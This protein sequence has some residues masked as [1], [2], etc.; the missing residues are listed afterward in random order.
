MNQEQYIQ[1][2]LDDQID[3][4]DSKSVG[5]Q[6]WFKG[7]QVF[8]IVASASIPFIIGYF[9]D[10]SNAPKFVI[11]VLG[12][13]IAAITAVLGIYKFQE[14]WLEYRTTCESLRHEKYLFLT[15]AAPYNVE[16]PFHLLVDRVEGLISNENT[17]WTDYMTRAK[18]SQN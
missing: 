6:Q 7:L 12:I 5:N 2:R 10:E 9:G 11:G 15:G 4:Y 17:N 3:W 8:V 1:E 14:N 13:A 18:G 16:D